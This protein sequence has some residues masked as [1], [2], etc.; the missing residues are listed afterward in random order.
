MAWPAEVLGESL[1]LPVSQ[2]AEQ[3]MLGVVVLA[4]AAVQ[5]PR[6]EDRHRARRLPAPADTGGPS[7]RRR[8]APGRSSGLALIDLDHASG[9]M[10]PGR[11]GIA[12]LTVF[13]VVSIGGGVL[14]LVPGIRNTFSATRDA[15]EPG[16]WAGLRAGLGAVVGLT[17]SSLLAGAGGV[18]MATFMLAGDP[19]SGGV[20]LTF[21]A[22]AA[23]LFG[24]VSVFGRRAGVFGTVLGVVI[25]STI[26]FLMNYHAVSPYWADVPSGGLAV[27]GLAVS[28]AEESMTDALN[29]P[30]APGIFPPAGVAGPPSAMPPG[31]APQ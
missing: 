5:R 30:P 14:W 29:Q 13:A 2:P 22:L 23:V 28:R 25:V 15:G 21:I 27:L 26:F 12:W 9:A 11:K 24:G 20:N 6:C 31:T 8:V 16:Q 3:I 19:E 18:A 7:R 4:L 17:G 1:P 10:T